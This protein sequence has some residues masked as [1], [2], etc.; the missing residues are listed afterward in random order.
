[1]TNYRCRWNGSVRNFIDSCRPDAVERLVKTLAPPGAHD[2][3]DWDSKGESASWAKSLPRLAD[4]LERAGLDKCYVILEYNPWQMGSARV[5]VIVAGESPSGEVSYVV[6]ELKQWSS[7]VFDP[8]DGMV[9]GTGAAYER[10]EGLQDPLDQARRYETFIRNYTAG[11]D[12]GGV[13][14]PSVTFHSVAFLHNE[15][16]P[17]QPTPQE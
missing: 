6:I 10:P 15:R 2:P 5:D 3:E 4:V 17:Q 16:L 13:A 9:H 7:C 11:M 12:G 14:D 1:M 8:T